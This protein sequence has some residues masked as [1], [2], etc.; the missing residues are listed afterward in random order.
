MVKIPFSQR[1]LSRIAQFRC[2]KGHHAPNFAE[3]AFANSH[4]AVKFA[5]VFS[6]E[7]FPL[8]ESPKNLKFIATQKDPRRHLTAPNFLEL[9]Y[10]PPKIMCDKKYTHT[11][12]HLGGPSSVMKEVITCPSRPTPCMPPNRVAVIHL[13]RMAT[14]SAQKR[15]IELTRSRALN[16]HTLHKKHAFQAKLTLTRIAPFFVHITNG[17]RRAMHCTLHSRCWIA[18]KFAKERNYPCTARKV[19]CNG[20]FNVF[21]SLQTPIVTHDNII[22]H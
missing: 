3:K 13:R 7:S 4:K 2:A 22:I 5:K 6:L 9:F 12:S 14:V 11:Q 1:K 17:M 15:V 8:F 18:T 20:F 16:S 21:A 10:N 19:C